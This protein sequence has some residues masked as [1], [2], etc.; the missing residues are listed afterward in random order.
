M[1][2]RQQG[3]RVRT[4]RFRADRHSRPSKPCA[5]SALAAAA[6]PTPRTTKGELTH[7]PTA[8]P[9]P[10]LLRPARTFIS[11]RC[12]EVVDVALGDLRQVPDTIADVERRL[13]AQAL[14][15]L[16]DRGAARW[17]AG[18]Q[19]LQPQ[20]RHDIERPPR[21][22]RLERERPR[23]GGRGGRRCVAGPRRGASRGIR[24]GD[25]PRGNTALERMEGDT[26]GTP[27]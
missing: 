10:Q 23:L 19:A 26:A 1:L 5:R 16:G 25:R 22:R 20:S 7:M 18:V 14:V 11:G 3:A 27:A 24:G 13:A 6:E 21:R 8:S 17:L 4:L 9:P 15:E 12:G 2:L